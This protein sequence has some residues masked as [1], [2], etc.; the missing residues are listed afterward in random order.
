M[1]RCGPH[2][3]SPR[4]PWLPAFIAAGAA[5]SEEGQDKEL[6]CIMACAV[7]GA[8]PVRGTRSAW[9]CTCCPSSA[10]QAPASVSGR[11]P[12]SCLLELRLL[13]MAAHLPRGQQQ[14]HKDCELLSRML[15]GQLVGRIQHAAA[16]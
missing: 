7:D 9:T 13:Q 14:A 4:P 8:F 15:A 3:G 1:T 10:K 16:L 6:N 5:V 11:C 2:S 12:V